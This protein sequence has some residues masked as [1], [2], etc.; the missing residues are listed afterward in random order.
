MSEMPFTEQLLTLA[1]EHRERAAVKMQDANR[2]AAMRRTI[3]RIEASGAVRESFQRF[4]ETGDLAGSA[5]E[6]FRG[7]E[8]SAVL[9]QEMER[10]I[11]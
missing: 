1:N 10:G 2:I 4:E 5:C 11:Q 9:E 3:D 6:F 7:I 8:A